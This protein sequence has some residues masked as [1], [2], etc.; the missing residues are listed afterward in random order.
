[1][2][3]VLVTGGS[4]S[5]GEHFVSSLLSDPQTAEVVVFGNDPAEQR[6][7]SASLGSDERVRMVLGDMRNPDDVSDAC[8]DVDAVVHAAA[9]KHVP[10][11]EQDP[12]KAVETNILGAQNLI[13]A[14]A[15]RGVSRV[16]A[17]STDKASSPSSLYGATKLVAERLFIAANGSP[18]AET[19]YATVRYGNVMGSAGS[20]VPL[21]R[22][23]APT[24]TLPLTDDRM[25]RFMIT[26]NTACEFVCRVL[27]GM[28][29]GEIFVFKMPSVKV[30]ELARVI[31]PDAELR[32]I[33]IGVG[34]RL[35]EEA[36]SVADARRARDMG[37]HYVIA[38]DE[39]WWAR[40][41]LAG[42]PLPE[43]FTYSSDVNEDWLNGAAL[44]ECLLDV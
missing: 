23:L 44:R 8:R 43:G 16:V 12:F 36:L 42:E 24:G 15:A 38:P 2:R 19:R 28:R 22:E 25:T 4:G 40:Q 10:V 21:F 41:D 35:H 20:V 11:A 29:G 6:R 33:G 32:R 37:D 34:E 14:C 31:A 27:D 26:V 30:V 17:I 39:S 1:M 3:R 5:F 7:M 18:E 9:I 13:D